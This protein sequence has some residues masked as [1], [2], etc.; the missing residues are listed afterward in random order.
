MEISKLLPHLFNQL[1]L[2]CDSEV[3]MPFD[4]RALSVAICEKLYDNSALSPVFIVRFTDDKRFSLQID[5]TE[6][7]PFCF[8][9]RITRSDGKTTTYTVEPENSGLPPRDE[10]ER[11]RAENAENA[12]KMV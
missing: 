5:T 9:A 12:E 11:W 10:I 8:I 3:S 6:H 2:C 1:S 4:E 7:T